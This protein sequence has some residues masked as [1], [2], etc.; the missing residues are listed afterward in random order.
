MSEIVREKE[1]IELVEETNLDEHAKKLIIEKL[2]RDKKWFDNRFTDME[3][4][5]NEQRGI[6]ESYRLVLEDLVYSNWLNRK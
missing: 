6:I 4:T 5:I 1:A 2:N 3:K